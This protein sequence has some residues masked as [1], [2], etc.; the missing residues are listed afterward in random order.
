MVIMYKQRL[1]IFFVIF[2][3]V[4]SGVG[5]VSGVAMA[6]SAQIEAEEMPP[7]HE[8]EAA[9]KEAPAPHLCCGKGLVCKCCPTITGVLPASTTLALRTSAIMA[10]ATLFTPAATVIESIDPP[11]RA[12]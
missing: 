1:M 4:V 8:H 7:C 6:A 12:I 11:P 9:K 5:S 10:E 2:C 3:L